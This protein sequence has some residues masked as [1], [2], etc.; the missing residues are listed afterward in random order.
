[1]FLEKFVDLMRFALLAV[2]FGYVG[3]LM[4]CAV[5]S[6]IV[7]DSD[8]DWCVTLLEKKFPWQAR[9]MLFCAML[10][11]I[12]FVALLMFTQLATDRLRLALGLSAVAM[13][14]GTTLLYDLMTYYRQTH[15]A[16]GADIVLCILSVTC[17]VA[18]EPRFIWWAA[19]DVCIWFLIF[20]GRKDFPAYQL[21]DAKM[22]QARR[23]SL[24]RLPAT[25]CALKILL[26]GTAILALIARI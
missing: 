5:I 10:G 15:W 13:L 12:G 25:G 9:R 7:T 24:I 22:R 21:T 26:L 23:K 17:L 20:D 11:V 19:I 3:F 8:D 6:A 2:Y 4:L 18:W 1:M 14:L 16:I